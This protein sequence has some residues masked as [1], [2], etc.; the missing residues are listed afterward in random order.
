MN[1][2]RQGWGR[3]RDRERGNLHFKTS[4]TTLRNRA[5]SPTFFPFLASAMQRPLTEPFFWSSES[6]INAAL[7]Q[8]EV[9]EFSGLATEKGEMVATDRW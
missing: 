6:R 2:F 8:T 5:P 9:S 1:E 4:T 7:L 3:V